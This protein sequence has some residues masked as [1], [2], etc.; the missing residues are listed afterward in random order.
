V[1]TNA[2]GLRLLR[3][4]SLKGNVLGLE[5][6]LADGRVLNSMNTALRK[7]NTGYDLNQLFIGSEGT[8]GFI[9]GVSILCPQKPKSTNLILISVSGEAFKSVID[10]FKVAKSELNEILSAFEFM[11]LEAMAAVTGNLKIDNPFAAVSPNLASSTRFYCLAETHGSNGEHDV[12]KLEKFYAKLDSLKLCQSAII[13]ES[14]SQFDMLWSLRER[15]AESLIRNGYNYKYDISLPLRNMYDLIRD[16]RRRFEANNAS[17]NHCVGY[18]HL[19]DGN[20]HLNITSREYDERLFNLMEPWIFEWTRNH[21]GSISAE[22][23]LGLKKRNYIHYS[24]SSE[25]VECMQALKRLF[26]PNLILNPYKTI[27]RL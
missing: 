18:G 7:D 3:Y 11:D 17:F 20:I 26:D 1:S 10:I 16:L 27:P 6:V 2:G 5:V 22:H 21:N 4:G 23:G 15:I 12:N 14:K 25:S 9:S 19:G 13:A 24:K 8:L